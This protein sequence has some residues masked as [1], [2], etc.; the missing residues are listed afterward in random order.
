MAAHPTGSAGEAYAVGTA[1]SNTIYNWNEEKSI[2][3]DLG[4]LRGPQGPQGEQ[5]VPGP[6][7][8]QGVPGVAGAQGVPGPQGEQG[9]QGPEGPQGPR[10]YPASVNGISPDDSGNIT[11]G[12]ANIL[13]SDG[14]T[15]V[16]A[17]LTGMSSVLSSKPNPNLLDNWYFGNPVNQ[18]GQTS[19]TGEGYGIDR[20]ASNGN[21]S[22]IAVTNNGIEFYTPSIYFDLMQ[23]IESPLRLNNQVLTFSVLFSEPPTSGGAI[24]IT[25]DSTNHQIGLLTTHLLQSITATVNDIQSLLQVSIQCGTAGGRLK[26][27]A[28]KLELGTTQTL[29]H[30]DEDG[31]W[32]LN[33]IPDYGEQLAR[34]QRYYFKPTVA[35]AGPSDMIAVSSNTLYGTVAFPTQMRSTPSIKNLKFR[36]SSAGEV[37]TPTEWHMGLDSGNDGFNII[38]GISG[39]SLITGEHYTIDYEATADL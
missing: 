13:R 7:G 16:E 28:V 2:W 36:R 37:L 17:A 27:K 39:V 10:G 30:Q 29:A 32:Q 34:C 15:N 4:P 31:N 24:R 8:E 6:Q 33:E 18:R 9:I 21:D 3:E 14:V 12:A 5:G 25:T 20:W 38:F 11:L 22:V 1:A 19:Y 23:K 35:F 26:I